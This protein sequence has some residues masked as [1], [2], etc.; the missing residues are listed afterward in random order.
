MVLLQVHNVSGVEEQQSET[1]LGFSNGAAFLTPAV[2]PSGQQCGGSCGGS[3]RKASLLRR[4]PPV[5]GIRPRQLSAAGVPSRVNHRCVWDCIAISLAVGRRYTKSHSAHLHLRR[6]A[7]V[8]VSSVAHGQALLLAS[9]L[10]RVVAHR[11][12]I[13]PRALLGRWRM[14]WV[15][16]ICKVCLVQQRCDWHLRKLLAS[17]PSDRSQHLHAEESSTAASREPAQIAG[18]GARAP[19]EHR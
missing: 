17:R 15:G 2:P 7:D 16:R 11:I 4:T 12:V 6:T 5:D 1:N 10:S 8:L 14:H 13:A 18:Q 3:L 19:R 9:S